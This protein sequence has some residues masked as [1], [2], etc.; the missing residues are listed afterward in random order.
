MIKVGIKVLMDSDV[1]DVSY[2]V[3]LK[4]ETTFR[5]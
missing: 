4:R 5:S 3:Q 2:S 1:S